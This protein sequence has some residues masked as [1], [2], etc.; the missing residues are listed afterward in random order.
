MCVFP[1][2]RVMAELPSGLL[3][4]CVVIGASTDK[5]RDIYQVRRHKHED[6][7]NASK[8]DTGSIYTFSCILYQ[9]RLRRVE[10]TA[11]TLLLN[12]PFAQKGHLFEELSIRMV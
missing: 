3:E 4:A 1:A 2:V 10:T 7:W 11:I 8:Q 12:G 9:L 6:G 5:L